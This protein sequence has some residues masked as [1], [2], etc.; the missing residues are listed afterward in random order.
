MARGAAGL[1]AEGEDSGGG[2][3]IVACQAIGSGL[4]GKPGV[5]ESW[6]ERYGGDIGC[7]SQPGLGK[8]LVKVEP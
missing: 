4:G 5:G 3:G 1:G 7:C 8:A 2:P 6:W